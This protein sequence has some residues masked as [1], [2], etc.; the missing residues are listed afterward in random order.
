[1]AFEILKGALSDGG[2]MTANKIA[3]RLGWADSQIDKPVM[4]VA[5]LS[6]EVMKF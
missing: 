4:V 1:M 2:L 3:R 6:R 5:I